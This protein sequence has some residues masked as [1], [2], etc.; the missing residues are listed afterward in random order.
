MGR[1]RG[2]EAVAEAAHRLDVPGPAG[3]LTELAAQALHTGVHEPYVAVIAVLPDHLQ[4]LL[5]A[6]HLA[7]RGREGQQ[8][9]QF[10]GGERHAF[11]AVCHHEPGPVDDQLAVRLRPGPDGVRDGRVLS[12]QHGPYAGVEHPGPDGFDHVV[13]RAGL[14]P[15]D[16]VDVVPLGGHDDDRHLVAVPD[17][18]AHVEAGHAG[19]HEVQ[20]DD[21]RAEGAEVFPSLFARCGGVDLMPLMSQTQ[22]D[23]LAHVWV[24]LDKQNS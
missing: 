17:A 21:V 2:A 24:V 7:G 23:G 1:S 3:G 15:H 16:H 13:V 14:Q 9:P 22:P 20:H 6:E 11:A 4:Q 18:P 8:Q 19:Q 10:G 5:A 12:A